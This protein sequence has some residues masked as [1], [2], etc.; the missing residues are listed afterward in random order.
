MCPV[1]IETGKLIKALRGEQVSPLA[2][3]IGAQI[4]RS[5]SGTTTAVRLGLKVSGR[6]ARH[7]R[8]ERDG[9]PHRRPAPDV[10]RPRPAMD[11]IDAARR[12]VVAVGGHVRRRARRVLPQLR[13]AQ[14]GTG[15][16]R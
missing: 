16:R 5:F 8:H 4:G 14:H 9:E 2:A 13:V 1:G 11:A 3:K 7:R 10:G 6:D 15:T 12:A